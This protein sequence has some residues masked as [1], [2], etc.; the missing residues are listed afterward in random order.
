MQKPDFRHG[1]FLRA[2][3]VVAYNAGVPR[4]VTQL[5]LIRPRKSF[6]T[7]SGIAFM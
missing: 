5:H 7:T 1:R 3:R 6:F 4:E 2:R